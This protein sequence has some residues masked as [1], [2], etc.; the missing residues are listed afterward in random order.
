LFTH[1]FVRD[2]PKKRWFK[3]NFAPRVVHYFNS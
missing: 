1:R 3:H 2:E